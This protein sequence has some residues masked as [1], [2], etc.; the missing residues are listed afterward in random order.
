MARQKEKG[1]VPPAV[2]D[3]YQRG[4]A[5]GLR[6]QALPGLAVA[7]ASPG[8]CAACSAL[9]VLTSLSLRHVRFV[10]KDGGR[11]VYAKAGIGSRRWPNHYVL[12]TATNFATPADFLPGLLDK[13]HAVD[14]GRLKPSPDTY[15]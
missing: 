7:D 14:E 12:Y 2:R 6:Q 13:V 15:Q 5:D 11:T 4:F 9:S 10:G 8:A 3:A 1:E